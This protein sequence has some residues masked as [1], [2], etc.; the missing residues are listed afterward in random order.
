[1]DRTTSSTPL[2][3]CGF[4]QDAALPNNA[5]EF[6]PRFDDGGTMNGTSGTPYVAGGVLAPGT[7]QQVVIVRVYGS[8]FN[9]YVDGLLVASAVDIG[10]S[11]TPPAVLIGEHVGG[12]S[13]YFGAFDDFRIYNHALSSSD[14]AALY[15]FESTSH[16]AITAQPAG[17]TNNVGDTVAFSVGVTN[18]Y[19]VTFQWTKDGITLPSG[20]NATLTIVNAQPLN[21]GNY[22][23]TVT[24]IYGDST[25]SSNALLNLNGVD[26]ALWQGLVAYYPF[27]GNAND[28]SGNGNNGVV[29]GATLTTDRFGNPDSAYHFG[30]ASSISFANS[31]NINRLGSFAYSFWINASSIPSSGVWL[32]DRTTSSTPLVSCGFA[33]DTALPNSTFEFA[34]RFDDGGTLNGTSGTPYDAGGVLVPGTWQQVVMVR[35]YDSAFNLYVNGQLVASAADVG[36]SLTPPAVLIGEHVGGDSQYLGAFDD[37]R[38]YNHGLSSNDVATLYAYESTPPIAI[39]TQPNGY[40]IY[41][42]ST[43]L[44]VSVSSSTPVSY[45]WYFVP[46]NNTGQAGAYAQTFNGFVVGAVVTNGGFGYGNTPHVSF[47]GGGG[48][49]ASGVG[50][51]IGGVVTGIDVTN[52]GSGYSSL[53]AVVIDPPNGFLFGQTNS[54]LTISNAGL[55]N[56]GNYYVV[57]SNATWSTTSSVVNLTLLFPPSITNQPQDQLA[58]AF[59]TATFEVGASG[60]APLSYQWL[61]GG[62]NLPGAIYSTLTFPSVIPPETG[63][64]SVIVA[65]NYGAVTSSIA[66]LYLAPYLE[67]PFTG[68]QTYWGQ[69]NTLSVGAWGSGDLMYQWYFNGVA[70]PDATSSNLLLSSVQFTNAGSY[71]VVVT[72][73]YGSVTN[74]PE[75]VIVNPSNVS[76]GLFAGVIIQGTVGYNYTIQSST[77]LN[78]PNSWVTLTNL[79]LTAPVQIWDDNSVNVHNSP[80]NFYRVLPGQ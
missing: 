62:T 49:G 58:N 4:A 39:T 11:L 51:N 61:S 42:Q 48:S 12:D 6:G 16:I 53:P 13:Q 35:A 57:V 38:I 19:P 31:P 75:Q 76:L 69:T 7:W 47:V 72:S 80:Q 77:D 59:S 23:V 3:S 41:G 29:N 70:I 56:L 52:A 78:D 2:V 64:Y 67:S 9:L 66:N 28:A 43:N 40:V 50:T 45:Q 36:S 17:T 79:T 10:S 21:I 5:F 32:I 68:L 63:P 46:A 20:T 33:Q 54:T 24:D 44:S 15:A 30:N 14:V 37:F 74:T 60:T 34:P 8:A 71:S 55:N 1:M 27:N 65:N 26:S 73:P 22:A 25:T 18:V